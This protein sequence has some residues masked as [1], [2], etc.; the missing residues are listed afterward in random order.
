MNMWKLV[1]FSGL[2]LA[3]TTFSSCGRTIKSETRTTT[4]G[5]ELQDL[6]TAYKSGVITEKEYERER[7]ELLERY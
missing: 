1:V 7:K 6:D 5:Q 3:A 4:L 2:M